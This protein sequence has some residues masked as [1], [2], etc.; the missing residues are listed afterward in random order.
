MT[1][2]L[3]DICG[4]GLKRLTPILGFCTPCASVRV[5]KTAPDPPLPVHLPTPQPP[6]AYQETDE[7]GRESTCPV[8]GGLERKVTPI[9]G[10]CNVCNE[11][12][13]LQ[14]QPVHD[15]AR[16]QA[17]VRE[18]ITIE[19]QLHTRGLATTTRAQ[20]TE[21]HKLLQAEK[22]RLNGR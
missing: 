13:P 22:R 18:L 4:T 16:E 20:L 2:H 7:L 6:P 10:L 14:V 5:L 15:L 21:R 8:C 12:R 9:M 19:Q 11:M 3:C 1:P 17:V